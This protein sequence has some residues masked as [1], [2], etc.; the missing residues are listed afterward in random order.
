[1]KILTQD[2]NTVMDIPAEVYVANVDK[3]CSAV[4]CS[5]NRKNIYL[6]TYSSSKRAKEVLG[7]MFQYY[8][9]GKNSYVMPEE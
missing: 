7:E 5:G 6:G 1:M 8:R 4:M 3:D 2:R 9:R